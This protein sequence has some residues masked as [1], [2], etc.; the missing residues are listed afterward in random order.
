MSDKDFLAII[1]R[2]GIGSW[3]RNA[4]SKAALDG[5]ARIFK[6]DWGS[7]FDLKRGQKIDV[8]LVDVTG[9]DDISWCGSAI[10][11]RNK[12]GISGEIPADRIK[13]VPVKLP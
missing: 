7:L 10:S 4:K 6:L 8:T 12:N 1:R 13:L 5:A 9:F 3:A 11:Y 2:N